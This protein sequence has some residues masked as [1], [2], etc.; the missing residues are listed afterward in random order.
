MALFQQLIKRNPN[1]GLISALFD[2][3][4]ADKWYQLRNH[5]RILAFFC[6]LLMTS[7][8]LM[9]ASFLNETLMS[10]DLANKLPNEVV[11][12]KIKDKPDILALFKKNEHSKAKGGVLILSEFDHTPNWQV[13]INPL[14]N[15]L[16]HYNWSTLSVYMPAFPPNTSPAFLQDLKQNSFA[17]ID[18]GLAYLK[19]QNLKPFVIIAIG[20]TAAML[21]EYAA[22]NA[23]DQSIN[24]LVLI[25]TNDAKLFSSSTNIE[26]IPFNVLDITAENDWPS[27]QK[28][29][30]KRL[31]HASRA[32]SLSSPPGKLPDTAKVKALILN[33]TGNLRYRQEIINGANHAYDGQ[34]DELIKSIRGWMEIYRNN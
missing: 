31:T 14:R 32:S 2:P 9:A 26:K 16:P 3:N 7:P 25:S 13:I 28:A 29:A 10:E 1:F 33:K 23:S 24:S 12:L 11:W 22:E 6:I 21:T 30:R 15:T 19:S 20:R 17:R 34:T 8:T 5:N 4:T 18:A 27:I